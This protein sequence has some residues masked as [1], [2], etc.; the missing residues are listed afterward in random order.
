MLM[1]F[2]KIGVTE[3]RIGDVEKIVQIVIVILR[4]LSVQEMAIAL[5]TATSTQSKAKRDTSQLSMAGTQDP[6][7]VSSVCPY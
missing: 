1:K 5:G 6:S 4:P 2:F 7:V 3:E